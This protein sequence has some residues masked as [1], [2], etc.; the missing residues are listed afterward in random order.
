MTS[1]IHFG[2]KILWIVGIPNPKKIGIRVDKDTYFNAGEVL[3]PGGIKASEIIQDI[4]KGDY[5]V[6]P[7][8]IFLHV[9]K[10]S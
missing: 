1:K 7:P 2:L 8:P 5:K 3:D 9:L 10:D 6:P 4:V